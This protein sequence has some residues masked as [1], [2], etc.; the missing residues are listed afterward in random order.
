[1]SISNNAINRST[2]PTEVQTQSAPPKGVTSSEQTPKTT[3]QPELFKSSQGSGQNSVISGETLKTTEE[4]LENVS[5]NQVKHLSGKIPKPENLT[6]ST[7]S[8][9]Q[10]SG[11]IIP[12]PPTAPKLP[13]QPRTHNPQPS[14]LKVSI[15]QDEFASELI[16]K[17]FQKLGRELDSCWFSKSKQKVFDKA[18]D[19]GEL[20]REQTPLGSEL[21]LLLVSTPKEDLREM[22]AKGIAMTKSKYAGVGYHGLSAHKQR[23][24]DEIVEGL[25][26]DLPTLPQVES[27]FREVELLS[28]QQRLTPSQQTL[29]RLERRQQFRG[30]D[31]I[32]EKLESDH[33][34]LRTELMYHDLP[35]PDPIEVSLDS[36]KGKLDQMLP[37][38]GGLKGRVAEMFGTM[39][40][41]EREGMLW[42]LAMKPFEESVKEIAKV[43][44]PTVPSSMLTGEQQQRVKTL[45]LSLVQTAHEKLGPGKGNSL[46]ES[47]TDDKPTKIT[48]KGKTYNQVRQ[49]GEGGFGVA[50]L[51]RSE[52]GK[53]EVVVKQFKRDFEDTN[54]SLKDFHKSE[55]A[56]LGKMQDEIRIHRYAMGPEGEGHDNVLGLKGMISRPPQGRERFGELFTITEVAKGGEMRDT[57]E[58]LHQQIQD[59]RISRTVGDLINRQLFAQTIE[60]MYYVQKERQMLHLDLKPE[61]I[62]LTSE[63]TV[64]VADF[65]LAGVGHQTDRNVGTPTYVDPKAFR[66]EGLSLKS[67]TWTLGV[68]ARELFTGQAYLT[69]NG[70]EA[71]EPQTINQVAQRGTNFTNNTNNRVYNSTQQDGG[72]AYRYNENGQA[73]VLQNLSGFHDM[74]NAMLHPNPGKRPTLEAIR[75]HEF[76]SDPVLQIPEIQQLVARLTVS[77]KNMS[78]EQLKQHNTEIELLSKQIE[79]LAKR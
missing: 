43:L 59:K 30:I 54:Q 2:V 56:W 48:Y 67:D 65:G 14:P 1:M 28:V 16:L 22:V 19:R 40:E 70:Q 8:L 69:V 55:E 6:S 58:R 21:M 63:G 33:E 24:V 9:S 64:K 26:K 53:D 12:Q 72:K 27:A 71:P 60:G 77:T 68:I 3:S 57:M 52:D 35:V 39:P 15:S 79:Q 37:I 75:R 61:N 23:L 42:T 38:D 17:N 25:S 78:T 49:L 50:F 44:Y 4:G 41:K 5:G 45:A 11:R 32:K 7:V 51:F 66:G 18:R 10:E 20:I 76:V 34:M 47:D 74:V 29:D 13:P 62:F 31:K 46:V 73:K 36:L